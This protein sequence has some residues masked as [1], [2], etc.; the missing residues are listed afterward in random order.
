MGIVPNLPEYPYILTAEM[1]DFPESQQAQ[2]GNKYRAV[3][4]VRNRMQNLVANARFCDSVKLHIDIY[5]GRMVLFFCLNNNKD[6]MLLKM[7]LDV[8]LRPFYTKSVFAEEV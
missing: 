1:R 4:K 2:F 8:P 6:V 5:S 7:L 3:Q